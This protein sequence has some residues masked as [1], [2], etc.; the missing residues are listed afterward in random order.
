VYQQ[1]YLKQEVTEMKIILATAYAVNPYKGSEDGMGWNFILQ[2]ARFNKIIAITRKNNRANIERYMLEFPNDLYHQISFYYFDL[3]YWMRFWKK[4]SRGALLYFW[5]WQRAIPNYVQKKKLT[6]DVVHNLNFHNDWTPSYLWKLKKPFVWGPIGHHP[7]IP[8]CYL[9]NSSLIDITKDRLSW[10]VKNLFWNLSFDLKKTI[11]HS[12]HILCMN[13]QVASH[14]HLKPHKYSVV[15]SVATEDLVYSRNHDQNKFSLLSVGRFIPLKGFDLTLLSFAHFI[16]GLPENDRGKC[17][18]ILVGSGPDK[19][20]Y[21]QIAQQNGISKYVRFIEWMDR[22]HLVQL[23][24]QSSAFIFPS[25]EGAG[26][27]V[28]E[29]L[30]FGLPIICLENSGPGEFVDEH[31]GIRI[32]VSNFENTIEE[33]RNAIGQLFSKPHHRMKLSSGARKRFETHFNWNI[34]GEQL[35]YIYKTLSI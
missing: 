26:M 31:C 6:Y 4:G 1:N 7:F 25:H 19:K 3:P 24:C 34:R 23:Y 11:A 18:L 14:L 27:V 30:S 33:L 22:S 17:E 9:K 12:N 2:I 15:P 16:N 8:F 5:L 35:Q 29:A 13:S 10:L 20:K 28:A 32:S 21:E